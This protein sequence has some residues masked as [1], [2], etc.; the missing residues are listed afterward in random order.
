MARGED[1]LIRQLSLL[2]FLLSKPRAFTAREIQ[3]SVEGYW[4]M[5]DETFTRRLHADRADLEKI[6]IHIHTVT[7]PDLADQ[8]AYWLSEEDFRLPAVEFT[9]AEQQ[10]LGLIL[11]VLEGRFAYA[12]PLRLALM[13][14]L[15]GRP[16]PL[17]DH[18]EHLPVAIAPDDDALHAGKQLARLEEAVIRSKTVRFRY[19]S[20]EGDELERTLDPYSLFLIQGRWYVVGFDHLRQA[21]R[22]F[23]V[24]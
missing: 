15:Q 5:S 3:E 24:G 11:A 18:W 7:S 17:Q 13:A 10:A 9:P 19:I 2:A 4:G 22:T 1:K 21:I 23:R 8:P 14:I 12:R 16:N 20:A 6:G